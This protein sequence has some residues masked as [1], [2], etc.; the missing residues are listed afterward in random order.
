MWQEPHTQPVCGFVL[1]GEC[2]NIAARGGCPTPQAPEFQPSSSM[3]V[4]DECHSPRGLSSSRK[5]SASM[6]L[7]CSRY[8]GTNV[9]S[10][11]TLTS[12]CDYLRFCNSP[13][14]LDMQKARQ[15]QSPISHPSITLTSIPGSCSSKPGSRFFCVP[16]SPLI[17][18][19]RPS[20]DA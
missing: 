18:I 2:P 5:V 16:W 17:H 3:K 15:G 19:S 6:R 14:T 7:E 11:L 13:R 10:S 12:V 9:T 20:V 4:G 1:C 8:A